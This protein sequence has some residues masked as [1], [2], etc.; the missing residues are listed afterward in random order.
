MPHVIHTTAI[1]FEQELLYV[2]III[3][4]FYTGINIWC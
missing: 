1:P 2:A 4:D 3:N